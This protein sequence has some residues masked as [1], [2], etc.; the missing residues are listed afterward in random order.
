MSSAL[1]SLPIV[2][3][4]WGSDSPAAASP[5]P[6]VLHALFN[7][8]FPLAHRAGTSSCNQMLGPHSPDQPSSARQ[9]RPSSA[10][11]KSLLPSSNS[12][13]DSD[14]PGADGHCTLPNVPQSEERTLI[15]G[16]MGPEVQPVSAA[17]DNTVYSVRLPASPSMYV[18]EVSQTVHKRRTPPMRS[19]NRGGSD[20][21]ND[22]VDPKEPGA[23]MTILSSSETRTDAIKER[24]QNFQ[25]FGKR[26]GSA[27]NVLDT[28][29]AVRQTIRDKWILNPN[30]TF[31][32][33]WHVIVLGM[34]MEQ[35]YMIPYRAAFGQEEPIAWLIWD[36]IS[37]VFLAA[38]IAMRFYTGFAEDG[39]M[40][41][42]RKRIA[43]R[44]LHTGFVWDALAS[45][46]FDFIQ[47]IVGTWHPIVRINKLLRL[48]RLK[49]AVQQWEENPNISLVVPRSLKLLLTFFTAGHFFACAWW[50]I[51]VFEGIGSDSFVSPCAA[52]TLNP[53]TDPVSDYRTG[54]RSGS[55]RER[56]V[57]AVH[58]VTVLCLRDHDGMGTF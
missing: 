52:C 7:I 43:R 40:V 47:P 22:G 19:H 54:S 23:E 16:K 14:T 5:S 41:Q 33:I 2:S 36:V 10:D 1:V 29:P 57:I 37:D 53:N 39:S 58:H 48:P 9:S 6:E 32:Q 49:Q 8:F 55:C 24:M 13:S 18:H 15:A 34:V 45:I 42:D 38:D 28:D 30:S 21:A 17:D 35:T 31:M 26:R 4:A 20:T 27:L 44:Y 51:G 50:A 11:T 3:V 46:P 56:Q 25:Q 12:P